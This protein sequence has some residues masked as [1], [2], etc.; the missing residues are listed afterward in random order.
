MKKNGIGSQVRFL[1]V[2]WKDS[3]LTTHFQVF[4]FR[5]SPSP[6]IVG[7]DLLGCTCEGQRTTLRSCF[8]PTLMCSGH[9]TQ[10]IR[11]TN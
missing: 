5:F 3:N 7:G 8:F 10:V 1:F 9:G 11:F 4:V 6:F 2:K